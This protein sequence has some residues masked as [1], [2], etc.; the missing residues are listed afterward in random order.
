MEK[1]YLY[2]YI[3]NN[4]I[5]YFGLRR[6]DIMGV[7]R[8]ADELSLTVTHMLYE[9]IQEDSISVAHDFVAS[10]YGF[11]KKALEDIISNNI[12]EKCDIYCN[13]I[14]RYQ[15]STAHVINIAYKH[16]D[17][18]IINSREQKYVI[19]GLFSL[20]RYSVKSNSIT[21]M[22]PQG[23]RTKMT[24]LDYSR[25]YIHSHIPQ[26]RYPYEYYCLGMSDIRERKDVRFSLDTVDV[27][28]DIIL[29][30]QFVKWESIEGSPYYSIQRI[31][32]E[33]YSND[34]R[35]NLELTEENLNNFKFT[36]RYSSSLKMFLSKIDYSD[37]SENSM[38]DISKDTC[39]GYMNKRNGNYGI[40][41]GYIDRIMLKSSFDMLNN[42]KYYFRGHKYAE[43]ESFTVEEVNLIL[44][45][46]YSKTVS[47]TSKVE[48]QV[49]KIINN[50]IFRP[51]LA[52]SGTT[53]ETVRDLPF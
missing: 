39:R 33:D 46:M 13:S 43:V 2:K 30:D 35:E 50:E 22:N 16:D 40:S 48:L 31:I 8:S 20:L 21:F 7:V 42:H 4:E 32:E 53:E 29:M 3:I 34:S 26:S 11:I 18:T 24:Y 51:R 36:L 6:D 44:N 9:D 27:F 12:E 15:N 10:T 47:D 19:K 5:Y 25:H 41:R 23:G 17:F 28:Y 49:N 37:T 45:S 38:I 52:E 14:F 1:V